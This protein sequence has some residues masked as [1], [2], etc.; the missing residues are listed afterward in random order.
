MNSNSIINYLLSNMNSTSV[1]VGSNDQNSSSNSSTV[2]SP[3]FALA[4]LMMPPLTSSYSGLFPW[5]LPIP[6]TNRDSNSSASDPT[7]SDPTPSDPTPTPSDP[8]PPD[9]TP[10]PRELLGMIRSLLSMNPDILSGL[11]DTMPQNPDDE[12]DEQFAQRLQQ[13][14]Y[15]SFV[16]TE[17]QTT[18]STETDDSDE[19]DDSDDDMPD[20]TQ[21]ATFNSNSQSLTD[22]MNNMLNTMSQESITSTSF[23]GLFPPAFPTSSNLASMSFDATNLSDL[24]AMI[25]QFGTFTG[26]ATPFGIGVFTAPS[27]SM[28]MSGNTYEALLRLSEMF[29]PVNKSVKDETL[30]SLP[31]VKCQETGKACSICLTDF[32][33]DETCLQLPKC[34]HLFYGDCVKP[35]LKINKVCPTCRKDVEDE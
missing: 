16:M 2:P 1:V 29:P 12:S 25:N 6:Q 22:L 33:M 32:E 35:W 28:P 9:S 24:Q 19:S 18:D 27:P 34:S 23:P 30:N 4:S 10:V 8:I 7:P 13:Q 11:L 26:I 14:E 31:E 3:N 17:R 15:M 21:S 20:L 5:N